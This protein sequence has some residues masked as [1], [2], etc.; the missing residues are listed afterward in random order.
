[1]YRNEIS[2]ALVRYVKSGKEVKDTESW[3]SGY[4]QC[5]MDLKQKKE[6]SKKRKCNE[7]VMEDYL[8]DNYN[9]WITSV[10]HYE[11]GNRIVTDGRYMLLVP[12]E[13]DAEKEGKNFDKDGN[14]YGSDGYYPKWK[15]IL[16]KLDEKV[17]YR[18]SRTLVIE[19]KDKYGLD[20]SLK[21][22]VLKADR[23]EGKKKYD[24]Y[25][26]VICLTDR[27]NEGDNVFYTVA[28]VKTIA[29]F[30]KVFPDANFYVD[31]DKEKMSVLKDDRSGAMLL[32]MPAAVHKLKDCKYVNSEGTFV[33]VN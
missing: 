19:E 15:Q 5:L 32:A 1:M 26:G 21:E 31:E 16:P 9:K 25:H 11:E 29:R 17:A 13:Y 3:R 20:N 6:T 33:K 27:E 23:L 8:Y 22:L 4:L 18:D 2:E 12:S 24:N 14:P 30:L 10:I 28:M 7:L